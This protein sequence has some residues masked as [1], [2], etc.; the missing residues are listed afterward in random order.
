MKCEFC[1]LYTQEIE[2]TKVLI[3]KSVYNHIKVKMYVYM[4]KHRK[5]LG[6]ITHRAMRLNYCPCCGKELVKRGVKNGKQAR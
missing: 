5:I 4:T 1:E 6:T 3:K 2:T